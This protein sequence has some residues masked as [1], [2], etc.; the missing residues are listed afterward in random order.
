LSKLSY[1][2]FVGLGSFTVIGGCILIAFVAT[3][4]ALPQSAD[5]VAFD[6]AEAAAS[7]EVSLQAVRQDA[8]QSDLPFGMET[9]PVAGAVAEKWRAVSSR[10]IETKTAEPATW[11]RRQLLAH[12]SCL[13]HFLRQQNR[14]PCT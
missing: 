7:I 1:G 10:S 6:A 8:T 4:P 9:E 14:P 11:N 3:L 13:S 2:Q 12:R 5:L